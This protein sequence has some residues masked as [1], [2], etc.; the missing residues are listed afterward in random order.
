MVE[1][2][3]QF[4]YVNVVSYI[5]NKF[6]I[7][8]VDLLQQQNFYSL[9]HVCLL[10]L[11]KSFSCSKCCKI[12]FAVNIKHLEVFFGCSLHFFETGKQFFG[13]SII[14]NLI[15]IIFFLSQNHRVG[16]IFLS[17]QLSLS[18][19]YASKRLHRILSE[20]QFKKKYM[21][22][23]VMKNLTALENAT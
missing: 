7:F 2:S 13:S 19:C 22:V 9:L 1:K 16:S 3:F 17:L 4:A 23:K 18:I 11:T 12:C 21:K 10:L 20:R 6:M 15:I 5:F 14:I 8:P